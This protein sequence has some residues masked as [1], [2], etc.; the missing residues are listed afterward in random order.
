MPP[1]GV[2]LGWVVHRI[3]SFLNEKSSLI[4]FFWG[5]YLLNRYLGYSARFESS[6][7][8]RPSSHGSLTLFG[9][10]SYDVFLTRMTIIDGWEH[11]QNHRQLIFPP[12]KNEGFSIE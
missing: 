6:R 1:P 7:Y 4:L 12:A 11:Q 5:G 10:T 8:T 2:T 9:G 3:P